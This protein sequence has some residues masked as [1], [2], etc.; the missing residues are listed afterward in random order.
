[1]LVTRT[2]LNDLA[3]FL[4]IAR[5]RNLRRAG[6]ELGV[7]A[8]AVSHALKS[9]EERAGVRL[10]NRTN[11]SVTLT[12]AGKALEKSVSGSFA[13]LGAALD[14]LDQLR[15]TPG[16]KIR[17]NAVIDAV[18]LVLGPVLAELS[19]RHPDIEVDLVSSN[20]I[21]DVVGE[22]FD[23]GVRYGGTV[24]EDMI[25]QRLSADLRWVVA[26]SPGYLERHGTPTHPNELKQHRCLGVRLG[27]D[28]IYRWE[29]EGPDGDFDVSI[30]SAMTAD[31]SR[32]T[33]A[34][35][36]NGG[37]LTFGLEAL[38]AKHVADGSLRLVLTEWATTGPGF[39]LYY[40]GRRQVPAGLR[41]LLAVAGEIKPLG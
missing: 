11:R 31:D 38:F 5:H 22:G 29:F 30:K 40:S 36:L 24:P 3:Y 9:F 27:D 25:A 13:D 15:A 12:S 35:A 19:C 23:A 20:R 4:A 33:L 37:G 14:N 1:M 6:L 17:I 10:I 7:S 41:A 34:M 32:S 18:T 39:Y 2:N 8:S 21:V 26:A 28:S 16:G